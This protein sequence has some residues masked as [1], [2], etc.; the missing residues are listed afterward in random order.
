MRNLLPPGVRVRSMVAN[1]EYFLFPSV[2][3][4]RISR[5]LMALELRERNLSSSMR[6]MALSCGSS[7]LAVSPRYPRRAPIGAR[8]GSFSSIPISLNALWENCFSVS[9]LPSL[10]E[11]YHIGSFE[12][13]ALWLSITRR[14]P[15]SPK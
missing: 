6:S 15:F 3:E 4:D 12:T 8:I 2:M 5:F 10:R 7:V 14:N 13:M 11:K 1:R 9:F